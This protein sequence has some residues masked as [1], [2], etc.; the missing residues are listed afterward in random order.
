MA[1]AFI[2]HKDGYWAGVCSGDLPKRELK[3]F[4][5]DF[6]ANG[7]SISTVNS[8]EEY[9]AFLAPLKFWHDSPE[10]KMKHG[11]PVNAAAA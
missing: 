10:W 1:W 7:F 3:R 9:N 11:K 2:A 5:G 6:A 8:R 4:L